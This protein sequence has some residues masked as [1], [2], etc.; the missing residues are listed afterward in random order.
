M[1]NETAPTR[2]DVKVDFHA[3]R[4][5]WRVRIVGRLQQRAPIPPLASV[6]A[7]WRSPLLS[8]R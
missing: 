4:P 1:K 5:H 7:N 8:E 3:T 6:A 2:A